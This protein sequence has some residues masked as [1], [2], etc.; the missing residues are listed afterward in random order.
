MSDE[1]PWYVAPL[2]DALEEF[3]LRFAWI[4]VAINLLGTGFG[5]WYY[6]WQFTQ[7]PVVMWPFVPD[8]PMATL[9]IALAIACW[10]LGRSN[11]YLNA[12][13]FFGCI[14][15]GL[16]TPYV[17]LAFFPF[18]G[19]QHPAMYNFLFWSHLAMV[20]QA[21]VIHR[22]SDFPVRAIALATGWYTFDLIVDY[23]YPIIGEPHHTVLPVG[24]YEFYLGV[25]A[26]HIAA[27][28]AVVL[29]IVPVFL[30]LTTRVK[31]L[32]RGHTL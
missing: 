1:L 14:K 29:T 6:R 24:D 31:T 11:E 21:F 23:F 25:P 7:T 32:E 19:T 12:L 17:L 20:V 8:S 3:G 9:L 10:K 30:A 27:A 5:F 2:P 4:V 26:L 22:F 16:W 15:L 13:A 18:Y 28:G